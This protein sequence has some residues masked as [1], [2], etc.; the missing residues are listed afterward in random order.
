[1]YHSCEQQW[2]S[3][4]DVGDVEFST[5]DQQI[6]QNQLLDN[7][8]I[9]VNGMLLLFRKFQDVH[10]QI[11]T[12]S[13]LRPHCPVLMNSIVIPRPQCIRDS[14]IMNWRVIKRGLS[15]PT[16]VIDFDVMCT[17]TTSSNAYVFVS[18]GHVFGHS[19]ELENKYDHSM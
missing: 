19:K 1:M 14:L 6:V 5:A 16:P 12:H 18:C 15:L 4:A 13:N 7:T 17:A 2:L 9:D 11:Q 10:L 3:I 8:I